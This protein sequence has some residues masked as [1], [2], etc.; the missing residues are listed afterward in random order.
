MRCAARLAET[1]GLISQEVVDRQNRLL[2]RIG[3]THKLG[4]EK[5]DQILTA[6]KNDKKS[7]GGAP[8]LILPDRIG[9]V[10]LYDWP[11]DELVKSA[12]VEP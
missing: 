4:A 3:L 1:Q 12:L 11:G 9:N 10:S 7:A 6:M 8:Q 5:H 2:D